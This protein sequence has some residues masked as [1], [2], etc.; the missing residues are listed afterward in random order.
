MA[1]K[2]KKKF[3]PNRHP[4]VFVHGMM[5][6]GEESMLYQALPYWGM[7]CGSLV[8]QLR[9]DGYE[10]YAPQV[11]PINS[12]WDRACEL[13]AILTGTQVDYGKDHAKKV[14]C[15]RYGRT[16]KALFPGWGK[17]LE[18]DED[19][20]KKV[21][22]IG[23]SFGGATIRLL[24]EL[25]E[26]GSAAE[27]EA[28]DPD[29]LSP[30]FAGGHGDWVASITAV[31]APHDG[32]TFVHAFPKLMKLL[33]LLVPVAFSFLGNSK[34]N[35]LYDCHLEHYKLTLEPGETDSYKMTDI[36]Q[37]PQ[38]LKMLATGN[39]VFHDLRID[40]AAELNAGIHCCPNT[41]YFSV[42]GNGTQPDEDEPDCQVR[43]PIMLF[44]FAPFAKKLGA[45]PE[46]EIG[47]VPVTKD[48]RA[49]DGLVPVASARYPRNEPHV[50]YED[51]KNEPL[52]KGVWHV[53]PDYIADHGTTIGGS[54]SYL[55]YKKPLVFKNYYY[56]HLKLLISLED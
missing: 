1:F 22:L 24:A 35:E 18:D 43:A 12:A 14:H 26:N 4:F 45:F 11:G 55:G 56:D 38:I 39:H 10:A 5:G 33:A 46:Q 49:N 50:L 29:D 8:K 13:Y 6:W 19:K 21:H 15:Q 16:Y 23:H 41:Y 3:E 42:A 32:T 47:G 17:P 31:S 7:V 51:V 53:L 9:A 54:L 25:L 37:I 52:K 40:A 34:F 48:W 20:I 44:A 27:Q 28:T 36:K 2:K 30:L